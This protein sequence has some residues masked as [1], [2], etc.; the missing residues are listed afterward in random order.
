MK[1]KIRAI[2]FIMVVLSVLAQTA[3]TF[4]LLYNKATDSTLRDVIIVLTIAYILAFL[5][6]AALSANSKKISR[7]ALGGY[8]RSQKVVKRVLTLLMLVMSVLN[9]VTAG[10]SG[11]E[12]ILSIVLI[13]YNLIVIYIDTLISRIKDKFAKK[14]KKKE[15]AEKEA[16]V[17]AYRVG[18][19][20]LSKMKT[21]EEK[22]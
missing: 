8:K 3:L 19:G 7:E 15:R 17:K 1:Q 18:N 14:R 13:V 21:S 9:F 10:G 6:I 5:L 2:W 11:V 16:R 12:F 4:F 22:K 20:Q